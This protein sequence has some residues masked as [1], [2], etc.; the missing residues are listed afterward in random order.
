MPLAICCMLLTSAGNHVDA[1][2]PAEQNCDTGDERATNVLSQLGRKTIGVDHGR[3]RT[4]VCVSVGY[5]PRPL[6]LICHDDNSTDVALQVAQIAAREGAEQIVVGFPLN[7]TSGEGEQAKYTRDFVSALKEACSTC[8]IMLWDERFSTAVARE[9]LQEVFAWTPPDALYPSTSA[10]PCMLPVHM[11][12]YPSFSHTCSPR[13][14][15]GA[16]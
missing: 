6:P 7:S 16:G 12:L 4:G 2:E 13:V 10:C 8:A 1:G 15:S 3:K 5:A 14:V 11:S 9:K